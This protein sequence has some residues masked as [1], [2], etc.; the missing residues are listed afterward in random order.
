MD[1][2]WTTKVT[3]QDDAECPPIALSTP[4]TG[5]TTP[6][7]SPITNGDEHTN[8]LYKSSNTHQLMH[9]NHACLNYPVPSS[10]IQ[11]IDCS[12]IKGWHDLT[13]KFACCHIILFPKSTMGH[14]DQ[15]CQGIRSTQPRM[16]TPITAPTP[17]LPP[18]PNL[19]INNHMIDTPQEPCNAHTPLV[20]MQK[21]AI[22]GIT[23]SEQTGHFPITSNQGNANI[24]I[25][26]IFDANY[27]C[28]VPIK[29]HLKGELLRAYHNT[30]K[31]MTLQDFKPLLHK[32]DNEISQKV[33]QFL[34]SQQTHLQYTPP[35][36]HCTNPT[37]PAICILKNKFLAG[38]A[39]LPK[40]FP[41]A[42]WCQLT[43]QCNITLNMLCLCCQ[44]P[45]FLTHEALNGSFLFDT[46]PMAPLGTEVLVQ[47]KPTSAACVDTTRQKAWYLSHLAN[48]YCCIQV[49]MVEP[50][51]NTSQTCSSSANIHPGTQNHSHRQ[52]PRQLVLILCGTGLYGTI[53][54]KISVCFHFM[55]YPLTVCYIRTQC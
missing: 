25:F 24:F 43:K 20:F 40:S 42:S 10:L 12:Y 15:V 17:A 33:E 16:P 39:G 29:N 32:Q 23:S 47:I 22:S 54:K 35:D 6:T 3:V 14:R 28:S 36:I 53:Q 9:Y 21:H 52:N 27:I 50:V 19:Y 2:G 4:P 11:A 1:D 49:I 31:W 44:N 38:I 7:N 34:L 26:Y 46:T 5:I 45:L 8:I 51:A 37:K 13:F 55:L 18:I 41:M 30:Y 48:H